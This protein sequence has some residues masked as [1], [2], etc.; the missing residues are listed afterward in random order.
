MLPNADD[1]PL[2]VCKPSI[3]VPVSFS[4]LVDLRFPKLTI[5]LPWQRSVLWATVPE[6]AIHEHGDL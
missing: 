5:D 1:L 2:G 4:I 3:C 6:A